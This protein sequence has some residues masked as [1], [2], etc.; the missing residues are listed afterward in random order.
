[1]HYPQPITGG[2]RQQSS[3]HQR[4]IFSRDSGHSA[5]VEGPAYTYGVFIGPAFVALSNSYPSEKAMKHHPKTE[6][7]KSGGRTV[8]SLRCAR[9]AQAKAARS[10]EN[11]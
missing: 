11:S 9:W 7:E 8:R 4:A 2:L 3:V 10:N 6:R 5:G 1:M